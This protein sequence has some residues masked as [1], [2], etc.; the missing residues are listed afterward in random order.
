MDAISEARLSL[1]WPVLAEKIRGMAAMLELEGI[2]IRVVQGLRTWAEQDA[3]YAQ[4]RTTKGI[5]V[6]NARGGQSWHNF[7]LAADCVPSQFGTGQIYNPDWNNA[8]PSWIRM[9][10]VGQSLGL[11]SGASWRSFPDAPH[12]EDTNGVFPQGSPND[13][14]KQLFV[15]RGIQA[16]WDV[17]ERG[18][19][20]NGGVLTT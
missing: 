9:E 18:T 17:L 19:P 12:F 10:T 14:A 8:H 16:V 13:E 2:E 1:V 4:G 11:T 3:L 7:G 20:F 15:S 5:I 6:T